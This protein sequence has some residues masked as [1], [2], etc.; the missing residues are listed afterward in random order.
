MNPP[1]VSQLHDTD[2][3]SSVCSRSQLIII[4]ICT[5]I[6]LLYFNGTLDVCLFNCSNHIKKNLNLVQI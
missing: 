1:N 6:F 5:F 4:I 2:N 3:L